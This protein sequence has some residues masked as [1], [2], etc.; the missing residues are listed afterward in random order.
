MTKTNQT[1]HLSNSE[2]IQY[3][4]KTK[5][6]KN[7]D[8]AILLLFA[9]KYKLDPAFVLLTEGDV[10]ILSQL[11]V[12]KWNQ[13]GEVEIV[14]KTFREKDTE[15]EL[16]LSIEEKISD[17]RNIFRDLFIGSMGSPKG[18]K[19]KMFRW[20]TE[21]PNYTIDDVIHAAKYWVDNKRK[22]VDNPMFIGQA[23]YFIFKRNQDGTES[24]RLSSVI[25]QALEEG[26]TSGFET[27][28]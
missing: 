7:K 17:Y 10:Q 28:I 4:K 3:V 14:D 8:A 5:K 19:D 23:D 1:I 13:K 16:K 12:I 6:I 21:N 15:R 18:V 27:L 20:L 9:V 25:E 2:I 22:E 11:N 24:S 26:E